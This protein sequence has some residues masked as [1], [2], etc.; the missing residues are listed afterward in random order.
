MEKEQRG[1]NLKA[2]PLWKWTLELFLGV[3]IFILLYATAQIAMLIQNLAL[4]IPV[5]LLS[6][7]CLLAMFLGWSRAFEGTWR[8]ELLFERVAP[9]LLKGLLVGVLFY[10]VLVCAFAVTGIYQIEYASPQWPYIF[11]CLA[12]YFLVACGEEVIFRGILFRMID[13][14]FGIRWA[15]VVSALLF[16]FV[17]IVQ[18]NATLWSSVAIAVEAGVMLGVAYKYAGSLWLPIGIHWAWNF[19]EG[20][21]FG[22]PVSGMNTDPSIFLSVLTG[23]DLLTGGRFGPEASLYTLV[24]GIIVTA[25]FA[26]RYR[27]LRHPQGNAE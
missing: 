11:A 17:H 5:V 24:L 18:P 16:G 9:N 22:F 20:N 19:S 8:W 26:A 6:G 4:K 10:C 2:M 13:E 27:Y 21:I 14:R 1:M 7:V 12:F 25:L 3:I 23:S 15:L